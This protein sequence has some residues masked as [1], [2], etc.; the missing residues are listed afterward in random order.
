E[1]LSVDGIDMVQFGPA[2][3]S[4]S[5]G[6][7]GELNHPKVREAELKTIKTA[8]KMD[9]S[10]RAEIRTPKDAEKYVKLGVRNFSLNTDVRVLFSWFKENGDEMRRILS[11]L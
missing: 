8:L 7:P 2:D 9:V 1:I 6:H 11:K 10:P 5:I 4:L 3:Y